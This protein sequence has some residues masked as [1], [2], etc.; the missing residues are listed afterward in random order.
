MSLV[1]AAT[2]LV[3]TG[4]TLTVGAVDGMPNSEVTLPVSLNAG[5]GEPVSVVQTAIGAGAV[6]E[7]TFAVSAT[8]SPGLQT[9]SLTGLS[10][11]DPFGIPVDANAVAGGIRVDGSGLEGEGCAAEV[12]TAD[13]NANESIGLTELLR[14]IQFFN[15]DGLHCAASPGATEDGYVPGPGSPQTCCPHNS[16]YRGGANWRVDLTELLRLIQFFNFGAYH[17]CAGGEDGFCPGT[18]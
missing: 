8:A 7:C 10:L 1:L 13:T 14:V 9:V 15:S 3:S 5:E 2:L 18:P 6:V 11:S 17:P 16:D 4:A 12:H